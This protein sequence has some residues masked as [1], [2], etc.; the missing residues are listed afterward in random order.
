[1]LLKAGMSKEELAELP[2]DKK[3]VNEEYSYTLLGSISPDYLA[4]LKE[5]VIGNF[6]EFIANPSNIYGQTNAKTQEIFTSRGMSY[7]NWVKP[8]IPEGKIQLAGQEMTIKLWD[9]NPLEDLFIGS[10]TTCCTAPG[11]GNGKATPLYLANTAINVIELYDAKGNAIG[12]SRIFMAD[13][14]GKPALIMDNFELN[15]TS[16]KD[17]TEDLL[18]LRE[19]YFD[20]A[21]K[22][23]ESVTGSEDTP[24][25]F[26]SNYVDVPTTGLSSSQV[27]PSLIGELSQEDIYINSGAK[28]DGSQTINLWFAR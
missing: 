15:N 4:I 3:N 20:Y 13:V 22:L 10:K 12:M 23:A 24:V 26:S 27:S 18:A 2:S 1:M 19:A 14:N 6:D 17:M 11:G 25:Y 5:A 8:N 28:K 7:E 21:K 9:R 16:K